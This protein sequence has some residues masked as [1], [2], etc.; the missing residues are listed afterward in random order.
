MFARTANLCRLLQ[1]QAQRYLLFA[2][3]ACWY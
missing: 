1:R 2:R 3:R